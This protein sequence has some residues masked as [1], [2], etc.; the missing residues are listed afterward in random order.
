VLVVCT[1]GDK[2][3]SDRNM[4][5]EK[6]AQIRE[7]EQIRAAEVLGISH[8]SFLRLPDQGLEDNDLFREKLVREIRTHRPEIVFTIDPSRP[9]INHRDHRMTGR[10]A[11]DAVFPYARDHLAYPQHLA[12]GLEPHKV[13]E[14]YLWG[15]DN[16]D[17][18]IDVTATFERKLQALYCHRSQVG[19]PEDTERARWWRQRYEEAGKKIGVP[20]AESFKRVQLLR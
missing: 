6:L 2:G 11:L 15:S 17:T 13:R 12:E 1:N 14:V 5:P 19:S 20:L 9:Y 8:V 10:V 3:T 18:Y 16:P 7:Q 4:P